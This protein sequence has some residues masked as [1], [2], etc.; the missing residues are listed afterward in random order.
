MITEYKKKKIIFLDT[1]KIDDLY[2]I[3][4]H[5]NK[6]YI[7]NNSILNDNLYDNLK[8]YIISKSNH[9]DMALSDSFIKNYKI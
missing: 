8:E 6:S 3:L 1:L 9:Y 2:E 4:N 7:E 5:V